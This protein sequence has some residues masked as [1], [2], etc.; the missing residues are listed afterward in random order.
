[1]TPVFVTS[2]LLSVFNDT[3]PSLILNSRFFYDSKHKHLEILNKFSFNRQIKSIYSKK[4]NFI[5][6][7]LFS[8]CDNQAKEYVIKN[9]QKSK[10]L[11]RKNFKI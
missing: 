7:F 4:M 6:F 3:L 10:E 11:T 2:Y 9:K 5:L 1:M 8:F